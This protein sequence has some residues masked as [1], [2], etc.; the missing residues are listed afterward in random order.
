MNKSWKNIYGKMVN[1]YFGCVFWFACGLTSFIIFKQVYS[2]K[3]QRM[4]GNPMTWRPVARLR[5]APPRDESSFHKWLWDL[6]S[7]FGEGVYRIVRTHAKGE[8]R[9]F[10]GVWLGWIDAEHVTVDRRY[11][12][13]KSHPGVPMSRQ[14]FFKKVTERSKFYKKRRR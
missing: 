11:P 12:E 5:Q 7:K 8:R 10:H 4:H 9:G 1:I 13:Y 6:V 14:L 3:A 2:E